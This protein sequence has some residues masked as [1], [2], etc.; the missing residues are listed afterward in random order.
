MEIAAGTGTN[1]PELVTPLLCRVGMRQGM[2]LS[3]KLHRDSAGITCSAVT[4][5]DPSQC[6]HGMFGNV[7]LGNLS[8]HHLKRVILFSC[9]N[10]KRISRRTGRCWRGAGAEPHQT[11]AGWARPCHPQAARGHFRGCSREWQGRLVCLGWGAGHIL[12]SRSWKL[13]Q[14]PRGVGCRGEM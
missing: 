1:A 2:G 10:A 9:S 7:G 12:A 8:E 4:A 11:S 3:G 13:V 6:S 14:H 5:I